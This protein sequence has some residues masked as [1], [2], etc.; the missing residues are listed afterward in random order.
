MTIPYA[1][2]FPSDFVPLEVKLSKEYN[3]KWARAAWSNS[4]QQ[5]WNGDS[6]RNRI[7]NNRREAAGKNDVNKFKN[8]NQTLAEH[9]SDNINWDVQTPLPA[10]IKGIHGSLMNQDLIVDVEA[11]NPQSG[12]KYDKKKNALI[13]TML[14]AKELERIKEET[15]VDYSN[16]IALEENFD[17]KEDIELYMSSF[18]EDTC[19][20]LESVISLVRERCKGE[21]IKSKVYMDL[22]TDSIAAT[23][24]YRDG[25][26]I[27][28][29]YVDIADLITSFAKN[30]DFSDIKYAGE[31]LD[32]TIDKLAEISDFTDEELY[33][34]ARSQAGRNGNNKWN[35]SLWG[36]SYYP[37]ASSGATN[38]DW[39]NFKVRVLDLEYSTIDSIEKSIVSIG[40]GNATR[41]KPQA[42]KKGEKEV[43]KVQKRLKRWYKVK[44]VVDTDYC[45]D[46]GLLHNQIFDKELGQFK[47]EAECSYNIFAPF[48]Y[49]QQNSS[50]LDLLKAHSDNIKITMI[51]MQDYLATLPP[52]VIVYD[53]DG[54]LNA[55]NGMDEDGLTPWDVINESRKR[56]I[57]ISST[58]TSN[59][60][61]NNTR[62]MYEIPVGTG[63]K[64][65]Q[66]MQA[67]QEF[68]RDMELVSGIPLSTI[69]SIDKDA[70]VG[71]EKLKTLNK[72]N[73]LRQIDFAFKEI[74][75]KGAKKISLHAIDIIG[76]SKEQAKIYGKAIGFTEAKILEVAKDF[77]I[78]EY[79]IRFKTTVD[80]EKKERLRAKIDIALQQGLIKPSDAEEAE[81]LLEKNPDKVPMRLRIAERKYAN[82]RLQEAQNAAKA[83][84]DAQM[85][86]AQMTHQLKMQEMQAELQKE[87]KLKEV[88]FM[89]D[90]KLKQLDIQ[91]DIS[92]QTLEGNQKL[93]QIQVASEMALEK[94]NNGDSALK[95]TSIN[96]SA[97]V[98]QP[99]I[100]QSPQ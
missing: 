44:W 17:T 27:K 62:P 41:I 89:Y 59:K 54:I 100:P 92:E 29:R 22:I 35:T 82:E 98:R 64:L 24:T 77:S 26:N 63:Q 56:G 61:F 96:R 30:D 95:D 52:D 2:G 51:K 42:K 66:Y 16:K 73:S 91:G 18:K 45:F 83:N 55:I 6:Q 93:Q 28:E 23:K 12:T 70:A 79:D 13:N 34:L 11:G 90:Y 9:V 36:N 81:A 74:W 57:L 1:N 99:S 4:T 38:S 47:G 37:Y 46:F 19:L 43:G 75:Q 25:N 87:I 71:I 39:K 50:I 85:Q 94:E 72:N 76:G 86:S 68:I 49:D 67:R 33:D 97:G 53:I 84:G 78:E 20:A 88:Q 40:K 48:I 15:G 58:T 10:F 69:A 7:I 21:Y 31:M 3:L 8:Q 65:V 5:S 14:L 32:M 60:N 80:I